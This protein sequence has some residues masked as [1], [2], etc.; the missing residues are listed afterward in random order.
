M[1]YKP[2]IIIQTQ[3]T[4]KKH[5]FVLSCARSTSFSEQ[6]NEFFFRNFQNRVRIYKKEEAKQVLL[7]SFLATKYNRE[8]FS[9]KVWKKLTVVPACHA[10][11]KNKKLLNA[12]PKV[13]QNKDK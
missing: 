1:Q 8:T 11:K 12:N 10:Y 4:Q 5:L 3:T 2:Q 6:K 13:P 9:D 7:R